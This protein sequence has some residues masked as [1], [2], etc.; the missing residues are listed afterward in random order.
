MFISGCSLNNSKAD[1]KDNAKSFKDSQGNVI[2]LAKPFQR[3][4]SLAVSTDEILLELV[5]L[6]N[7]VGVT[8]STVRGELS[9]TVAKAKLVPNLV[10]VN[11]PE[12]V[13]KVQPDLVIIPDFVRKDV[14]STL[15]EMGT[16]VFVYKKANNYAEVKQN[17]LDISK[18]VG[19]NPQPLL[20]YMDDKLQ[21]LDNKLKNI[22]D[23]S[24]KRM[25]YLMSGGIYCN[26]HSPFQD[27]CKYAGLK[28]A[29]LEL[30]INKKTHLSKEEM[31]KLNPDIIIVPDFNWDGK[32]FTDAKIKAVLEDSAYRDVKAVKNKQVFAIKGN[33]LYCLSHHI[34][35]ASEDLARVAYPELFK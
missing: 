8:K 32:T 20:Q 24:R 10:D 3:I 25:V 33:H 22:P 34:V 5:P 31:I 1:S 19:K 2:S 29:T 12:S 13:Y 4:V 21:F 6:E 27:M 18:V 16:T 7:I 11:S 35:D 14:V 17:I 9:N 26:P 30:N 28:D 23:K 15:K